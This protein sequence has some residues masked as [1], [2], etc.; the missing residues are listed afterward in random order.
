MSWYLKAA[1]QGYV[2]AMGRLGTCYFNGIGVPQNKEEAIKWLTAAEQN[3]WNELS[4]W[5]HGDK[6]EIRAVTEIKLGQYG[7]IE[8]ISYSSRPSRQ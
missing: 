1:Q 4:F 5:G 6:I 7:D 2:D 8:G 3:G